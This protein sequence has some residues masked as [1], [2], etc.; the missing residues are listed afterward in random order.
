MFLCCVVF[1]FYVSVG[2]TVFSAGNSNV[3][4]FTFESSNIPDFDI[5]SWMLLSLELYLLK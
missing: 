5:P 4:I 3:L 2:S 1:D